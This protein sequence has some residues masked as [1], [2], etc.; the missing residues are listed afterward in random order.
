MSGPADGD[1]PPSVWQGRRVRLRAFEPV[2]WEI[3][4]A[5]DEDS[6]QVRHLYAIPFPRSREATKRWAEEGATR[7]PAGDDRRFVIENDGGEVV[8][9]P[10][11]HDCDRRAGTFA[12]GVSGRAD[13]RGQGYAS[14]AVTLVLRSSFEELRY[15]KVTVAVYA[16]NLASIRLHER[17]GFQ[18]EG[19]LRRTVYTRGEHVDDL[20]FD[21]T[22]EEFAAQDP[23]PDH[24]GP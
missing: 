20:V 9:D 14:E 1:A 18:Q 17:R 16:F 4:F 6:D 21:S 19:R 8:G 12:Y 5:W 24:G 3:C 15:Q 2:D 22:A 23:R 11:T 10:T 13:R 7:Q